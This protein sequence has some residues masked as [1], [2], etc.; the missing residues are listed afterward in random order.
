MTSRTDSQAAVTRAVTDAEL[1]HAARVVL[2][3][4]M[5]VSRQRNFGI[6]TA[7]CQGLAGYA[8]E[9]LPV[10]DGA[11]LPAPAP[12]L[13]KRPWPNGG[14]T[15]KQLG[16][17]GPQVNRMWE[18]EEHRVGVVARLDDKILEAFIPSELIAVVAVLIAEGPA[19]A[20]Q[21]LT[22][23]LK[24]FGLAGQTRA[25]KR[26]AAGPP[27]RGTVD[28]RRS[29]LTRLCLM[30]V[31]TRQAA[32]AAGSR[33]ATV[34]APWQQ[35]PR[36]ELPA[37]L[38]SSGWRN[39]GPPPQLLRQRW[40]ELDAEIASILVLPDDERPI[41]VFRARSDH[42]FIRYGR[43]FSLLRVRVAVMLVAVLGLRVSAAAELTRADY[44]TDYLGPPP[45]YRTGAAL[46]T[47]PGKALDEQEVRVKPLTAEMA[48]CLDVYLAFLDRVA[49]AHTRTGD[50]PLLVS[51]R[52]HGRPW[53][54]T[55]IR[56]ALSGIR[57]S[58]SGGPG[59]GVRPFLL[60]RHGINKDIPDEHLEFVG[61]PP[62][63]YRHTA[64]QL[65][66][67]AGELWTREHA[68]SD[69]EQRYTPEMYATGLLDHQPKGSR[70]VAL[71]GDRLTRETY[72]L[73]SGRAIE[74]SWRLLTTDAGAVRRPDEHAIRRTG[75]QIEALDAHLHDLEQQHDDLVRRPVTGGV[76]ELVRDQRVFSRDVAEIAEQLRRL[77]EQRRRLADDLH[78]LRTDPSTWLIIQHEDATADND[79]P[80]RELVRDWLTVLE[81]GE[82]FGVSVNTAHRWLQGAGCTEDRPGRPWD[83]DTIPAHTPP[84]G[85][86]RIWVPGIRPKPLTGAIATHIRR[87]LCTWPREQGW[88]T[89]RQPGPRCTAPIELPDHPAWTPSHTLGETDAFLRRCGA[90]TT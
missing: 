64:A 50:M 45:D 41:D 39:E 43:V 12:D 78:R 89:N 47:R 87:R 52:R 14:N 54:Q 70:L 31:K 68:T 56:N 32:E 42:W 73:L 44:I 51:D 37:N 61:Y 36:I 79:Q 20:S 27:A 69:I 34:L 15:L 35:A 82:A 8:A 4:L 10:A 66:E 29:A 67:R 38:P 48:R 57:P 13:A 71:Y 72:E 33:L 19:L 49:P 53:G 40:G 9:P 28:T 90:E 77:T 26:R 60:R 88:L 65:A 55:G 7:L 1:D 2:S 17:T 23:S 86:A 59:R 11:R 84:G 24:T 25:T 3:R 76:S 83:G 80:P 22:R 85:Y 18:L 58:A 63:A 16:L 75:Q 6:T 62:H 46:R 81:M 74:G 5:G 21:R 30:I